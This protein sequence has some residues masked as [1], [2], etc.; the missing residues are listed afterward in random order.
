MDITLLGA[1]GATGQ[2]ILDRAL[3]AGHHVTALVRDPA[4]LLQRHEHLTVVTGDATSADDLT[5]ALTGNQVVISALGAS[6]NSPKGLFTHTAA[7]LISAAEKTGAKRLIWQASFGVGDTA[8]HLALPLAALL[9]L[10]NLGN[11]I[12]KD[13]DEAE[14]AIRASDLDW[15]IAYTLAL[16]NGPYT[17]TYTA[18][19]IPT[20]GRIGGKISRADVADFML[21]QAD[22]TEWSHRHAVL[23]H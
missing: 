21:R 15:T 7:A 6:R 19:D 8:K 14:S 11:G 20:H 17:G 1:T 23:T 12:F 16:T 4:R 18:R 13:K 3:N 22:G 5:G 9:T 2:Q 10:I